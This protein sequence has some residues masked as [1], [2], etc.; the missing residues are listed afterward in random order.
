MQVL[1]GVKRG[2]LDG[3]ASLLEREPALVEVEEEGQPLIYVAGVY[4]YSGRTKRLG[5]IVE[6]LKLHGAGRDIFAAAYLDEP[7][8]AEAT[9]A[10]GAARGARPRL[11]GLGG[12]CAPPRIP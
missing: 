8:Q 1:D 9:R 4:G 10:G 3:L 11:R 12:R 2:D 7:E 5:K 6:L